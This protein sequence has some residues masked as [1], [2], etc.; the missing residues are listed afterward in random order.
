MVSLGTADVFGLQALGTCFDLKLDL[1]TFIEGFIPIHLDG[2]VVDENVL[3]AGTLDKA[4]AF[5]SVEP[6]H[7]TF[8]SHYKSPDTDRYLNFERT[9]VSDLTDLRLAN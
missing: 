2:G 8:F 3:P 5:R 6:F 9:R 4:V 7:D 1:R